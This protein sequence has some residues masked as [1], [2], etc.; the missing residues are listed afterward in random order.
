[1]LRNQILM[2]RVLVACNFDDPQKIELG[3]RLC[4]LGQS[5]AYLLEQIRSG[6]SEGQ[7]W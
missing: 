4:L 7:Q 3:K 6:Q 2:L 1:M 5:F